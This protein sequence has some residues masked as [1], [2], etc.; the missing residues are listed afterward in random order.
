MYC[1]H[2]ICFIYLNPVQNNNRGGYNVGD[3]T[4][5]PSGKDQEKQYRMVGSCVYYFVRL[6]VCVVCLNLGIICIIS[7][8][9]APHTFSCLLEIQLSS[10]QET[11]RQVLWRVSG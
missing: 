6:H 11:D 1:D 2:E 9:Y 5:R 7:P 4:D 8:T 10:K 3:K